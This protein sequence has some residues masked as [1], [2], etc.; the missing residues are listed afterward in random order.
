VIVSHWPSRRQGKEHSAPARIAVAENIAFLVRDLVRLPP[1]DYL[2]AK[3]SNDLAT[4]QARFDH[5]VLIMGD[6]NDEPFDR[7][8]VDYLQASSER[9]RVAGPTNDV[10]GFKAEAADYRGGDTFLYNASWKFLEPENCGTFYLASTGNGETFP[11]RY[12]VLDQFVVSRGLLSAP[13]VRLDPASVKIVDDV[14]V[15]TNPAKRP[16]GF[17]RQTKRG[18]SDHLPITAL[19]TY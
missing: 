6:F 16:R 14:R 13:G 19:L 1:Q 9:D 18:T 5:P 11:N 4:V 2:Q 7:S 12:Q 10:D 15:A 3:A 17:D 8:V